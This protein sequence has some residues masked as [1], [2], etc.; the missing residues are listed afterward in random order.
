MDNKFKPLTDY[1]IQKE[2]FKKLNS[3][4]TFVLGERSNG[5]KAFFEALGYKVITYEE[6]KKIKKGGQNGN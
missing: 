6:Y 5:R 3:C 1:E 2:F 4:F